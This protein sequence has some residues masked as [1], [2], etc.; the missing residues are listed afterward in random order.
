M[1]NLIL[2]LEFIVYR[3]ASVIILSSGL[4]LVM[5]AAISASSA[6]FSIYSDVLPLTTYGSDIYALCPS[7]C[8]ISTIAAS[9]FESSNASASIYIPSMPSIDDTKRIISMQ[10]EDTLS[11]ITLTL[12]PVNPLCSDW[13]CHSSAA[14]AEQLSVLLL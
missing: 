6:S 2:A 10:S 5:I 14:C 8:I 12:L 13:C 4:S 11:I 1:S 9:S 3:P 7:L